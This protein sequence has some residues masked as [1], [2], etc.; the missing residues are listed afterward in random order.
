M[1]IIMKT[2]TSLVILVLFCLRVD[3]FGQSTGNTYI[4]KVSQQKLQD[5]ARSEATSSHG[6][7]TIQEKPFLPW[8]VVPSYSHTFFNK[9]R[10]SWQRETLDIFYQP[11]KYLLLGTSVDF[12]HRP[13]TGDD[14]M[15][16]LNASWYPLKK[17]EVHGEISLTPNAHFLPD[18][19]YSAGLIYTLNPQVSLLFDI[20]QLNFDTNLLTSG[21]DIKQIKSGAT[22]MITEKSSVTFRYIHGWA[23]SEVEYD[24]YS[25]SVIIGEMPYDGK[26]SIGL[27]YGTDPD[28]GFGAVDATL[29]DA[30]TFS[31][32][33]KKPINPDL[34]IFTG[35]EYVYRLRPDGRELYQQ[36]TPIVETASA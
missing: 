24:Y 16:S 34:S 35:F 2:R 7:E 27:A 8:T 26:L 4:K 11:D 31:I 13:P 23:Y 18:E 20:Q 17:L 21:S 3:N 30:Y 6:K 33:Y 15:Y 1:K 28:L 14:V 9:G 19:T 25:A 32:F 29:S 10:D 36:L 22:F 12:K 5:D